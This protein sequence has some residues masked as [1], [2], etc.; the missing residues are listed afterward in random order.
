MAI[1]AKDQVWEEVF[2][3]VA[4]TTDGG[5]RRIDRG[6]IGLILALNA[7]GIQT[8]FSCEGHLDHGLAYPWVWVPSE[9]QG[10]LAKILDAF[11]HE[12]EEEGEQAMDRMLIILCNF[13]EGECVLQS[14]GACCQNEREPQLKA[15]KLKEYQGEM[16]AFTEFLRDRFF[17]EDVP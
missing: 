13:I 14:F 15:N 5:G 10:K 4:R 1:S 12:H 9:D 17:A 11:N 6:I 7:N 3:R 8:T 2:D 16:A